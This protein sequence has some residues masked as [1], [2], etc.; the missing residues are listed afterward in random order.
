MFVKVRTLG[1]REW[2]LDGVAD[3]EVRLDPQRMTQAMVQLAQNAV[4]H[5]VPGQRIRIGSRAEAGR[6]GRTASSCTSPTT[7][8][9][10]RRRTPR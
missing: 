6:T 4:Q 5:T 1:D 7:G 9:G 2:Q 10:S 8:P 3:L